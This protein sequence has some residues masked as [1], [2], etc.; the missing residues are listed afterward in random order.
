MTVDEMKAAY[1]Q[2]SDEDKAALKAHVAAGEEEVPAEEPVPAPDEPKAKAA[3]AQAAALS[4]EQVSAMVPAKMPGRDSFIVKVL[5]DKCSRD[6]VQARITDALLERV[7]AKALPVA[8][9]IN[10]AARGGKAALGGEGRGP[11]TGAMAAFEGAVSSV[12][13]DRKISRAEAI[14]VVV[15]EQP[16]VHAAYLAEL[17][18]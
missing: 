17:R 14:R 16:A 13:A 10:A 2:M 11:A 4:F 6:Q 5:G 12:S 15:K 1:D 3:G 7:E 18:K 8:E 9:E